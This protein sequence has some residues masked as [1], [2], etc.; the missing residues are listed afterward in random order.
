MD[1]KDDAEQMVE[2]FTLLQG[3]W[4]EA[5]EARQTNDKVANEEYEDTYGE[6]ADLAAD[7]IGKAIRHKNNTVREQ[8]SGSNSKADPER[9]VSL[10]V[11][12]LGGHSHYGTWHAIKQLVK[13]GKTVHG[14]FK[15]D[16]CREAVTSSPDL[17]PTLVWLSRHGNKRQNIFASKCLEDLLR[18]D[19]GLRH[20]HTKGRMG[21]IRQVCRNI[22][23]SGERQG[24]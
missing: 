16:D 20:E 24:E 6:Q 12:R 2:V 9:L 18:F 14:E 5:F 10:L 17:L 4:R 23:I 8:F 7:A 13:S 19:I 1:L 3:L 11:E 21:K 22:I 15:V